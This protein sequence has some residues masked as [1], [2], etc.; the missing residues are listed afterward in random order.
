MARW[1]AMSAA[2]VLLATTSGL[3]ADYRVEPTKDESPAG[4]LSADIVAQLSPTAGFKVM[5]GEK[6]TVC[7]IWPAKK[8]SLR[9]DFKPSDT[10]LFPLTSGSLVGAIRFGRKAADF[11]GQDIAAGVYTL[12]YA[13][14]PVDGNHVGTFPTRDFLLALPAADD[15]SAAPIAEMDLFKLSAKTTESTHPAIVPLVKP[16]ALEPLPGMRHFEEQDWWAARFSDTDAKVVL[17]LIV[18]GKAAE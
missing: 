14:Q 13:N 17:E 9:S 4:E 2:L 11:R 5:Q 16:E 18:V 10:I 6:R 7:E 8:W 12:R 15:Q 1:L 3:A